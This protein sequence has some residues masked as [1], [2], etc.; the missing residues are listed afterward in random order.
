MIVTGTGPH[1]STSLLYPA[2]PAKARLYHA[3]FRPRI[4]MV[5]QYRINNSTVRTKNSPIAWSLQQRVSVAKSV[6][7]RDSPAPSPKC[8]PRSRPRGDGILELALRRWNPRNW[9]EEILS[10]KMAIPDAGRGMSRAITGF[11]LAEKKRKA[12]AFRDGRFAFR[13]DSRPRCSGHRHDARQTKTHSAGK[14]TR[15]R[16]S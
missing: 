3:S 7:I 13:R 16:G 5:R 12:G 11:C 9:S 1:S 6:I 15:T 2:S 14:F 8:R 4:A 10:Q